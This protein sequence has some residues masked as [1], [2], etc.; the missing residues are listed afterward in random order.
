M[1]NLLH[2]GDAIFYYRMNKYIILGIVLVALIGAGIAFRYFSGDERKPLDTGIVREITIT[3][4]KDQWKFEP[5]DITV[6]Q[7]D[8]IVLTIINEDI[9]DHGIAIDAFGVSERIPA[10]GTIKVSFVATQPGEFPFYCSVPCGE[11]EKKSCEINGARRG[12]IDQVGKLHV[13]SMTTTE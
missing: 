6:N 2:K 7:G 13:K 12:H 8:K 5:D 11:C 9:Y 4:K 10:L 1:A 3:T